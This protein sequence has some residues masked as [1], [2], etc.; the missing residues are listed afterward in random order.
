M[1]SRAPR[2]LSLPF[3]L[4]TGGLL[5]VL[6]CTAG[7]V[8]AAGDKPAARLEPV[9]GSSISE[10]RIDPSLVAADECTVKSYT[11]FA[12]FIPGWIVGMEWYKAY[13]DPAD[14][15]ADPYPFT[16]SGVN[17]PMKFDGATP[18]VVSVDIE[19]ID[20]T[21][22]PGCAVPGEMITYSQEYELE[23]PTGGGEFNVWIPLDSPVTV[24][25]PFYAGFYIGNPV[26]P[27]SNAA[28]Y[29]DS[30]PIP[31]TSWDVWD[32]SVGWVDLVADE[33]AFPG[34]LAMEVSGTPG[35]GGGE[36]PPDDP[37]D[38]TTT[39]PVAPRISI[40]SP[41]QDDILYASRDIWVWDSAQSGAIDYVSFSF[42]DG[43]GYIEFGRDYD[44]AVTKR[45]GVT[46]AEGGN[47]FMAPFDI[48]YLPEGDYQI[49]CT[50]VD[51]LGDTAMA[52]IGVHVDPTPPVPSIV[53]LIEGDPVCTPMDVQMTCSD[54]DLSYIEVYNRKAEAIYSANV[55]AL[56]QFSVGDT[57]GN[58]G[59][60]NQAS[61]G[62]FGD[63]YSAPTAAAMAARVWYDRGYADVLRSPSGFYTD[64]G[65]AEALA[66]VFK[67]RENQGTYD[68]AVLGG[69]RQHFD[70]MFP[71]MM[72]DYQ[73]L[74]NYYTVRRLVEDEQQT[75]MLGLAGVP[76]M[77]VT[78]DGFLGW[79]QTDG[80]FRV[81][82]ANPLAGSVQVATWR[83]RIGYSELAIGGVWHR[84]DLVITMH[85][86]DWSP[87]RGLVG[88][89]FV[90]NDGW[91][92]AWSGSNLAE[93]DVCFL[94]AVGRD[95]AFNRG[96]SAVVVE[97]NCSLVHVK[98]DYN[99]DRT[100]DAADLFYLIDFITV[101]SPEPVG[102][103]ERA[104]CNCDN[105]I[106]I[107]DIVYY[108]NFLFG[109]VA[110]PCR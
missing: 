13:I 3:Q 82:V 106:N 59:D 76:G 68:D 7:S 65:L 91:Q 105:A 23:V 45:D 43:G 14:G 15:C 12:Y 41:A 100:P 97:N 26:E 34:R 4:I 67:T 27:S 62:E 92:V 96:S 104:D 48:S 90:E 84:V 44:G 110:A 73:R 9:S 93:G 94:R 80:S 87:T 61:S 36:D 20:S 98:G 85:P 74:P 49:V 22:Q 47:G 2:A 51:T 108:M 89:D 55:T 19:M 58:P 50:A 75:A 99:N 78:V 107:A 56:S 42:S 70:A 10:L 71:Q 95:D 77:W 83:D 29:T 54:E 102:G 69:L 52:A 63:Y 25:G 16:V 11:E 88:V 37:P 81:A 6:V 109:H 46:E 79:R 60:G 21:T 31:C 30:I 8:Q 32:E 101:G 24:D 40:I 1:T 5:A 86:D 38:D 103:P 57:N 33:P 39:V 72:F 53:G 17:M 66:E 28:V 35:G 64:L 18:L